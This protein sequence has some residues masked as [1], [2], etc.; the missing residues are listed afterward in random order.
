M[1]YLEPLK[2]YLAKMFSD[3]PEV[4]MTRVLLFLTVIDTLIV[5]NLDCLKYWKMQD[6][7]WGA[8]SLVAVLMGGKA[9]QKFAERDEE[10]K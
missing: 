2:I 1:K 7:P 4:S 9:V 10:D 6:I 8:V 3:S 5:W